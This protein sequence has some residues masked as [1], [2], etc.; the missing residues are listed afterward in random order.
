MLNDNFKNQKLLVNEKKNNTGFVNK[1]LLKK[2]IDLIAEF[3][4]KYDAV[5][6]RMEFILES[7]LGNALNNQD[8]VRKSLTEMMKENSHLKKEVQMKTKEMERMNEKLNKANTKI[9][10]LSRKMNSLKKKEKSEGEENLNKNFLAEMSGKDTLNFLVDNSI[11][12]NLDYRI[13]SLTT[14]YSSII[15]FYKFQD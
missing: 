12:I 10:R 8:K 5:S 6:K 1:V 3:Q 14:E 15:S 4:K 2:L 7:D 11:P 13:N 9:E